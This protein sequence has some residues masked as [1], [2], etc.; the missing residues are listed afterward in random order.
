VRVADVCEQLQI[1]EQELRED[2]SVL[3]V[4]NFGGGAYVI[5]AEVH[6]NGEIEVDPEPYSDTF[7]RPARLLPIEANALVA[8]IDLISDHLA[9]GALTSAREKIVA[10]L[11]HDPVEEGLHVT[12]PTADDRIT[13]TVEEAVH[14]SRRLEIEYWAPNEDTFTHRKV[15]PYALFNSKEAWYVAAVD[16][17]K[18]DLRSFRLD[19]IKNATLLDERFERR[20]DLDPVADIAGWPRTGKVGGSRIARVWISHEQARWAREE[21]TVLAELEDGAVI[22][23]WTYKGEPYL[24]REILKEAGDAAV[25]E[26][27]DAREAVLAAAERLLAPSR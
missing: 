20:A 1:S 18:D 2:V 13:R 22:V 10:A 25:L 27:A 26:P 3:N 21:R 16:P 7:D 12:S 17:A 19:R 9:K 15:E 6:P 14:E 5:Y 11:G 8:A 24:V 4:V 23:E